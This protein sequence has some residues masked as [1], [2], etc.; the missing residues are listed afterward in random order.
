MLDRFQMRFSIK[1]NLRINVAC[2]KETE[3]E[4]YFPT[5][6][7]QERTKEYRYNDFNLGSL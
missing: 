3:Q 4:Y 2:R 5:L 6:F 7:I 1:S